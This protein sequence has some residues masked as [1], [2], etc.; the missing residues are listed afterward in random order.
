M[1]MADVVLHINEDTGN[2]DRERLRDEF[3]VVDGVMAAEFASGA[4]K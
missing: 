1:M 2:E 3:L 4:W